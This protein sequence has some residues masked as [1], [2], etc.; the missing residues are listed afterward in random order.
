VAKKII[1]AR[2]SNDGWSTPEEVL[3]ADIIYWNRV[4]AAVVAIHGETHMVVSGSRARAEGSGGGIAHVHGAPGQWATTWINTGSLPPAYVAFHAQEGGP[5]IVAF[6]GAVENRSLKV[7][8]GA[9]VAVS[10]DDGRTWGDIALVRDFGRDVAQRVQLVSTPDGAVHLLWG[11]RAPNGQGTTRVEHRVS[12][13]GTVWQR[14]T[15]FTAA[16]TRGGFQGAVSPS[17]TMFVAFRQPDSLQV[18]TSEWDGNTWIS[19]IALGDG[20]AAT[21]PRT[22]EF[23]KD[24]LY[25]VWARSLPGPTVNGQ[26]TGNTPVS[27]WARQ[28]SDCVRQR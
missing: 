27:W 17:G 16:S 12:R 18:R 1:S 10:R 19:G 21:E 9:F 7:N 23:K 11:I 2:F 8:N 26:Q 14:K 13:D 24:S 25:L 20:G 6:I 3:S 4:S 15:E 5:W 28:V 22:V